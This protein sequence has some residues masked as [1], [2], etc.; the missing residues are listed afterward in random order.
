MRTSLFTSARALALLS[1]LV[2]SPA[3]FA[4]QPAVFECHYA[5]GTEL[6]CT[7]IL[8]RTDVRVPMYSEA[9]ALERVQRLA[10]AVLCGG[11]SDCRVNFPEDRASL[12]GLD[13][14]AL[15]DRTDA[16]LID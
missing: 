5:G 15:V 9:Y 12:L 6:H 1:A 2:V 14:L 8:T 3:L 7:E 4:A 13:P 11:A 10:R 16:A